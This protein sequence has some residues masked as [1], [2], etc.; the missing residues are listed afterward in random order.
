M[1]PAKGTTM[2]KKINV[3]AVYK[4]G[5]IMPASKDDIAAVGMAMYNEH[6]LP[7]LNLYR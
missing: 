7:L 3:R 1:T 6:I 4:D 5:S 2:P